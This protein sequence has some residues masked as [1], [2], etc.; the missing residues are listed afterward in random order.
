MVKRLRDICEKEALAADAR[1]LTTLVEITNADVRSCLNTLQV[2]GD[3]VA[4]P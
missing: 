2:G 4:W 1:S 3:V